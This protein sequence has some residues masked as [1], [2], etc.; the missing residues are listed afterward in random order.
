[1]SKV[2]E[3][4]RERADVNDQIQVLAQAEANGELNAEQVSEFEQLSAK[5]DQLT[6]QIT[7]MEKAEQ[8]AAA[9]A[10]PVS[11]HTG[12][13][14]PAIHVKKE[15]EQYKGSTFARTAMS[16]AAA[17]GNLADAAKFAKDEIG[18]SGVAMAIETSG[19]SAG[20][21]I[22]QNTYNEVI[23]LLRPKTIVRALGAQS[24]PLS[25][26]NLSIPRMSGGATAGY[27]GEGND[28]LATGGST[29]DI[30][31][32]AKTMV[33]LVPISN[34]LIGRAG[35]QVEQIFLQDMI[36]AMAV[37]EDKAFLRDDGTGN[38]PT[39]F[40]SIAEGASQTEAWSGTADLATIDAYL[41][42]LILK[43]MEADSLLVRPGWG[44]SPRSYMK[45]FGLRDGNGNKVYPEMAQGMLKG[46]PV[47]HTT[48]VPVNLGAGSDSEIY[49]ADWNDVVIGEDGVMSVDFSSEAAYKD[50]TDTMVSAFSRNQSLI[51]VVNEH[52]VG[53]RHPEGLVLGTGVTW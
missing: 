5:F 18:D 23:E 13:Q 27:V 33:T 14:T 37:R 28:T 47:R 3:L 44:L 6:A 4:R 26:G 9:A 40:K 25:N 52:D 45:L 12:G 15:A 11:A 43:L 19:G 50:A 2:E 20:S 42:S 7:R 31:L 35:F 49:F 30:Q 53:F 39:G 1:M 32:S 46:F 51:R 34:Q 36:A 29:D 21:L 48:T 16:I 10:Q 41:D 22:P 38:T 24:V 8:M 17:K